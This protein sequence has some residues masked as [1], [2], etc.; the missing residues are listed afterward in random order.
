MKP[1]LLAQHT[2]G[3]KAENVT[4][5]IT[6]LDCRGAGC[7]HIYRLC[8]NVTKTLVAEPG[9]SGRPTGEASIGH[10]SEPLPSTF[11]FH[12]VCLRPSLY[13]LTLGFKAIPHLSCMYFCPVRPGLCKCNSWFC[14]IRKFP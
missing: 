14:L 6:D 10:N 3:N 12:N 5:T 8:Y 11:Y 7:I 2:L 13:S 4:L 9:G 1:Q